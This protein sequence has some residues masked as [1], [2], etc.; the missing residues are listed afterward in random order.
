M[1]LQVRLPRILDGGL[2]SNHK[3]ALGPTLFCQL[4]GGKG[5]PETHLCIPQKSRDRMHVLLPDR[6]E[7]GVRLLHGRALFS[8]HRE[9]LVMRA[10]ELLV[11]AHLGEHGLQ[12][13]DRA[14]HP[15]QF[16]VLEAPPNKRRAHIVVGEDSPI[17]TL[18]GLVQ[19][20]S[21]IPNSGSLELLGY[22]TFHVARGLAHLEKTGMCLVVNRVGIDAGP[23]LRL[24]CKYLLNSLLT[25]RHRHRDSLP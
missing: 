5:L 13:L 17:I 10:G 16:C 21:E 7:V 25:H 14:A 8:A 18:G 22:T 20:D 23:R 19:L 12:V 15:L 6:V 11:H 24:G 9:C 4:V 2:E 1:R 3:H